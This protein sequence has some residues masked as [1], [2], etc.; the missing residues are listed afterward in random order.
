[1]IILAGWLPERI[2]MAGGAFEADS[3]PITQHRDSVDATN[4]SSASEILGRQNCDDTY[5]IH[6]AVFILSAAKSYSKKLKQL[7]NAWGFA[8][9]PPRGTEYRQ[10]IFVNSLG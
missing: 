4:Q 3:C 10:A 7:T 1:M 8:H 5:A 2:R 9:G 6:G